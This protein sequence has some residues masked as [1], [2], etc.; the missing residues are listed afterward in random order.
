MK[1]SVVI[2][3]YNEEDRLE[4]ALKSSLPI[5]DE[6]VVVDSFS[7][8][9]TVEIAARYNA[10]VFR[11]KFVDFGSQKNLAMN[12]AANQWVL[13]LDA[14]ERV[15]PELAESILKLKQLPQPPADGF[16]IKRK[17]AYLGRWIRHSGWYPDKKLRLFRKDKSQWDGRVH[18][19]LVLMGKLC[20]LAGE[21]LH[22][23]YRHISDH[24]NRIN[25]YSAMQAE[26]IVK[27]NKKLLLL[28][29]LLLPPITFFRFYI[30]KA[31]ILDGFP[32]FVIALISSWGTAMKYL[33][34]MEI[35]R[36]E[37]IEKRVRA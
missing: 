1:V 37:R 24:V 11:H 20:P 25:R 9:K 29:L 4:D 26:D 16:L 30:W 33:K 21:I 28:R 27:K 15:S 8:D 35:K 14:D 13:N 19:R 3:T 31:G 23:T 10:R 32:G 22:Y 6:I 2:I 7:T 5:A 34:A 12:K 17:T 18:E 36:D